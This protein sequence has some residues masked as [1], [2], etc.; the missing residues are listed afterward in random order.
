[1]ARL[2]RAHR[3]TDRRYDRRWMDFTPD[4]DH[5]AIREGVRRVCADFPDEYWRRCDEAHEFPWDFYRAMAAG[6]WIGIAIPETYGGGG[7]GVTEASI[8]LEEVAASGAA[9]NGCSAIHLSIFGMGP[10]IAHGSE[11]MKARILPKVSAGELHVAFGVTEP[12]AGTDTTAIT[13]RATLDPSGQTYVVRGRK[14][15]TTKAPYCEK[16]LLLVRTTPL[17]QSAAADRGD[18]AAAGRPTEARGDDHA[19][20]QGG[21]KRGCVVRSGLR[22]PPGRSQRSSRRG[23]R[24]LPPSARRAQPGTDPDC[25]RGRRDRTR[26]TAASRR[27]RR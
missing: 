11:E 3:A 12:D 26:R 16:V 14:V 21:A 13:T 22:R 19:D 18:D 8:V 23:G 6:G 17:A 7:R 20:R 5:D 27:V 9:M 25:S 4:P 2:V 1:M 10:V 15:W 24:G